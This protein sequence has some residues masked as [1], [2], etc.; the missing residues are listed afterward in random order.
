MS[1]IGKGDNVVLCIL[2]GWGSAP[3]SDYNAISVAVAPNWN[4]IIKDFPGI[5]LGASG[6]EVGLPIGQMGNS[7]VG[8]MTIGAGRTILQDL[9]RINHAFSENEIISKKAI[10]NLVK[11]HNKHNYRCHIVGICSDG[12]VHGHID[13]T[14]SLIKLLKNYNI[15]ICLHLFLDGRD[16]APNSAKKFIDKLL[17]EDNLISGSCII[18][19][20]CGRYYGMDRD[21]NWDR[22]QIAYEMIAKA[23]GS[24]TDD[25]LQAIEDKYSIGEFD[26][27]ISPIVN[28]DYDGFREGDSILITNFRSDR[29]RQIASSFIFALDFHHFD[30][31]MSKRIGFLCSMTSYSNQ[32]SNFF[33][34]ILEDQKH[35]NGIAEVLSKSGR[36][37]LRIAETEKYAHVTYFFNLGVE[38]SYPL[39]ERELIASPDIS[40]YFTHPE[41]SSGLITDKLVAAIKEKKHDFILVNYAAPD[42]IGH[43]GNLNAAV[44]AVEYID[45]CIG[46]IIDAASK[47]NTTLIISADHG[48]C[49]CMLDLGSGNNLTSHT[50]NLVPFVIVSNKKYK[51]KKQDKSFS[52]KDIAP[53]ILDIMNIDIPEEMTGRSLIER[54]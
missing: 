28:V 50:T 3:P 51:L 22:T 36:R 40:T 15:P 26:E 52:L 34:V 4:K 31:Q 53:T 20:V 18:A 49:E 10:Q 54:E 16:C 30:I 44:R 41:M 5:E 2:D 37:Q 25:F 35:H 8:H 45:Y 19:S 12:G 42:M 24:K 17:R 39:E 46:R 11:Y 48:N 43:T 47:T 13:H 21:M 29:I 23:Q 7:E 32:I 9:E 14:I 1:K 33:E 6:I 38:Q 27:F